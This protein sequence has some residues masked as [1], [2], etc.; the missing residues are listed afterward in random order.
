MS[1]K[2]LVPVEVCFSHEIH[3]WTINFLTLELSIAICLDASNEKPTKV[4]GQSSHSSSSLS[5]PIS[6]SSPS[7]SF[8]VVLWGGLVIVQSKPK[9]FFPQTS[10]SLLFH[11][12][13]ASSSRCY[14][15]GHKFHCA[16]CF[17]SN[18][19]ILGQKF[20]K[21]QDHFEKINALWMQFYP[22]LGWST[23]RDH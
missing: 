19:L 23:E 10:P 12:L 16:A 20:L 8:S 13:R 4:Y 9:V 3:V 22:K 1:I 21:E 5:T 18:F 17:L 14:Q 11:Y 6:S 2:T 7:S 15:G